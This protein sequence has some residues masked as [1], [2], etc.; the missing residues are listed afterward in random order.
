MP[1][2][3]IPS[4]WDAF[5]VWSANFIA[6]L[7]NVSAKYNITAAA[8]AQAVK[9]NDWVQYWVE[10]KN[11]AKRQEKQLNDYV[12]AVANGALNDPPQNDPAYALPPNLPGI[13]LPGIKKRIREI[14][15]G[16]K[17]QKS[18]YTRA[19]GE[20]LGIVTPD[21][22]GFNEMDFTPEVRLRSLSNFAVEADFRKFGLDALRIDF[23]YKNGNWQLAATLTSSPGVFNI[24]PTVSGNAEQIEIRAVFILKNQIFGNYSPSYTIVIQP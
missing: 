24:A 21:E 20:L 7:P 16:I 8:M 15:S 10:A 3:Y 18:I 13:V 12:D 9:D 14:A 19:D 2:D 17:A 6:Q 4:N 1:K 5:A 22:A 11:T 23:R